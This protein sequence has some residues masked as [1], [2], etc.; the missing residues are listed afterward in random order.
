MRWI[1]VLGGIVLM[2]AALM[3]AIALATPSADVAVKPCSLRRLTGCDTVN[4]L[5]WRPDFQQALAQFLGRDG[6]KRISLLYHNGRL[7]DQVKAVLGGP[8]DARRDLPDGSHLFTACR[9]HSCDEKGA[10]LLDPQG[11]I[12]AIAV[13]S[14]HCGRGPKPCESLPQLDLFV[15]NRK[16]IDGAQRH[17]SQWA[18]AVVPKDLAAMPMTVHELPTRP[19]ARL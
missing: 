5:S 3:W 14:Y 17:L 8:P 4:P 15:R 6:R 9:V 11:E 16:A 19:G 12:H 18:H 2:L 10:I 13:I 7:I 1:G